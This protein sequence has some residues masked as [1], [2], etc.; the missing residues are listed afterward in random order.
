MLA[1]KSDDLFD[2]QDLCAGE[3][4][5]P[6]VALTNCWDTLKYRHIYTDTFGGGGREK[7]EREK[8]ENLTFK[9]KNEIQGP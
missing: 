3:N 9:N 6:Q 4:Q 8:K 5:L 7:R 2:L 1:A